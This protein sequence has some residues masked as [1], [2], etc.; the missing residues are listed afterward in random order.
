MSH[1]ARSLYADVACAAWP[2]SIVNLGLE[3]A[4]LV[5]GILGNSFALLADA[6][7]SWEDMISTLVVVYSLRDAE[8]VAVR[9]CVQRGRLMGAGGWEES[10]ASRLKL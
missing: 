10:T 8:L 6:V 3:L 9:R 5:A 7:N 2:G 4:K 1:R